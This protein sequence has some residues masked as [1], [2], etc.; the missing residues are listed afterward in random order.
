MGLWANMYR[1]HRWSNLVLID[2]L[3]SLTN[4]QLE[5]TV[6]GTYGNSLDT[7]RHIVSS[8]ADYVRI[9]PDTPEVPQIAQDGPFRG[10]DR[11]REVADAA[12]TALIAYV[13]DLNDDHYFID[14]D[15]GVAFQLTRSMLLIQIIHHATEHRSQIRTTLSSHGITPPEISTWAWRT[16][17][18]GQA[19]L[20]QSQEVRPA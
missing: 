3:S 17:D 18:D 16:S 14:I 6:R 9:L 12:D 2:F 13:T 8:N 10:W 11:L 1:H 5:L 20:A 19:V 15:D 7:I 4:E